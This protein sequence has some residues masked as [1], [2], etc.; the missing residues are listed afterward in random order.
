MGSIR[1][2]RHA[3]TTQKKNTASRR[4]Q[5]ELLCL[6]AKQRGLDSS[7]LVASGRGRSGRHALAGSCGQKSTGL[8]R[9][10]IISVIRGFNAAQVVL[11]IDGLKGE[12]YFA[13]RIFLSLG[14]KHNRVG[15]ILEVDEKQ[16][17]RP[18]IA[19][20][21]HFVFTGGMRLA[22]GHERKRYLHQDLIYFLGLC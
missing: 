11:I 16:D 9:R 21:V 14:E 19:E 17:S 4:E 12:L 22:G 3:P 10:Q 13:M 5:R 8:R 2:N 20:A 7:E 1:P 6:D 18:V 15:K